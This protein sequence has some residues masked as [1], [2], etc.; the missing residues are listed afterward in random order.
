VKILPHFAIAFMFTVTSAAGA[1]ADARPT[2][3]VAT[4][5]PTVP[6]IAH[7]TGVKIYPGGRL[8]IPVTTLKG[9]IAIAYGLSY[10]QV[11]GGDA[12]LVKDEYDI[13]AKPSENITNL[14]H[15]LF[16]I[17]DQRLREML[18]GFL[19]DRFQLRFHRETKTGKVYLLKRN[20]ALRLRPTGTDDS[21]GSA[22]SGD[23]GFAAGRWVISNS[24]MTQLAKYA[25]RILHAP[26]S[27]Q[28]GLSGSFDYTQPNALADSEVN[29]S[30]PSG[31]FLLLIPELG[32]KM[33]AAKGPVVIFVI[34]H[35]EKPSSN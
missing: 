21:Q 23:I 6:G 26:V 14:R 11:S 17:E 34:D 24:S 10:W 8:V 30:D 18:Q 1:Q 28:T 5:K 2:F 33:E 7:T 9:L 15:S 20:G 19:V 12:W 29:Y 35:A 16:G 25:E 13:E 3:E 4:V 31:P 27:D 32:L 22:F